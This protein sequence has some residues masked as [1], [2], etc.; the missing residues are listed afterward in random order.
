[1]TPSTML[2]GTVALLQALG[3]WFLHDA[4]M[5]DRWPSQ[6]PGLLISSYL[7]VIAAPLTLVLLW[8]HRAQRILWTVVVGVAIFFVWSANPRFDSLAAPTSRFPDEDLVAQNLV[9]YVM[10]WLM[11]LP[12]LRARLESGLWLTSYTVFF[13]AT[14]RT[15]LTLAEALLFTGV[16]WALLA[17]WAELF[18]LLGIDFFRD[19][20]S[21]PRF[22]YPAS[23]LAFTAATRIVTASE[24]LLDGVFDQL[25]DVLKWL[26]PMAGFIVILF[27]LFLIPRL[28]DLFDRGERVL[29]SGVLIALVAANVLF[30][31][32]GYRDGTRDPGYGRWLREAFRVVPPLLLVVSATALASLMIRVQALGLTPPRAW[33]VVAALFAVG[34][35][36][37]YSWSALKKTPWLGALQQVNFVSVVLLLVTLTM[38]LTPL[39]DPLRW[40]V[41][42]QQRLAL[43]ASTEEL[44]DGALRFL[45]FDA[46][47]PGRRALTEL[48]SEP[49]V[50]ADAERVAAMT[51]DIR[52][53]QRDPQATLARYQRWRASLQDT[54]VPPALEPLLQAQ[55]MQS[56]AV[57]DPDGES[58]VPQLLRLD[59][60][61]DGSEDYLLIAGRLR[62]KRSGER[63]YRLF[64]KTGADETWRLASAG[65]ISGLDPNHGGV[66]VDAKGIRT[67][68]PRWQDLEIDGQRLSLRS[69]P[70]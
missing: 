61:R 47:E 52:A 53:P 69:S 45:R 46:G 28:V 59:M 62:V 4:V 32:A 10:A 20:F 24:R 48:Q 68:L 37:G 18:S 9:P 58:P 57:L 2:V 50:G 66:I 36:A 21:D 8:T 19:L 63:D 55:F 5:S 64:V 29:D 15:V 49:R 60:D 51:E 44:R 54:E 39:G 14:W 26:A 6:D 1:M 7:V 27:S 43:S 13:H 3:L 23:T 67:A 40:S 42:D 41:A 22:I 16:F 38:S 33:G 35:S 12:L 56:R 11:G 65:I 17:L 70:P 31:N 30:L 34:I 25:L